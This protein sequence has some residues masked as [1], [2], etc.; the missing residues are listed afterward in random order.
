M[1]KENHI[2]SEGS[3][4]VISPDEM[5]AWITLTPPKK[6]VRYTAEAVAAWLPQQGVVYGADAALIRTAVAS[7]KYD[8]L[9][10]VARGDRAIDGGGGGY[11]IHTD[12]KP[13]TGLSSHMDGAL[14]YDD[15]S[16]LQE[17]Q[18]GEI[19]AEIFPLEEGVPGKTVTGEVVKPREGNKMRPLEGEGYDITDDGRY[20]RAPSLSHVSL[21]NNRLVVTPLLKIEELHPEQGPLSFEGNVFVDG[22]IYP[23]STIHATGSIFVTGGAA[24]ANLKAGRHLFLSKGMRSHGG[25]ATLEAEENIWGMAFESADITAGGNLSSNHLIGCDARVEGHVSVI[26]GLGQIANTSLYAKGGVLAQTIGSRQK[27]Q[28]TIRVGM[29]AELIE[30]NRAVQSRLDK[31]GV[32]VQAVQQNINAHEQINR[33]KEGKGR[34]NP[35]YQDMVTKRDQL[36]ATFDLL[37]TERTRLKRI[38]DQ[39]SGVSIIVREVIYPGTT[40][41]IDTYHRDITEPMHRC[42]F[43]RDHDYIEAQYTQTR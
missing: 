22:N 1:N 2:F 30:R 9:L 18:E 14:H 15:L 40:I 12:A 37:T 33:F 28:T 36:L 11:K 27:D 16:F 41:S 19:L 26:G 23:G 6:G 34:D 20:F 35:Q 39:H 29:E 3:R 5:R 25:I 38:I 7:Q 17:A 32:D 8:E 13:F 43:V 24:S 10:E 21:A 31:L 42:K 4:V